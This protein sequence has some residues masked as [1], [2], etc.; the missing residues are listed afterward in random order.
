MSP[1]SI[2]V[3]PTTRITGTPAACQSLDQFTRLEDGGDVGGVR[4]D[5]DVGERIAVHGY[6]VGVPA[7]DELTGLRRLRAEG[8]GGVGGRRLD[9]AFSPFFIGLLGEAP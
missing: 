7:C 9:L 4:E 3:A 1:P 5:R 2:P 8:V 6:D